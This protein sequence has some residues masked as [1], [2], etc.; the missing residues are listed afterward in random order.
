[1]SLFDHPSIFWRLHAAG[2]LAFTAIYTLATME[3]LPWQHAI[4][5]KSVY[6]AMGCL[7]S[8]A[9]RPVCARA[10]RQSVAV[11]MVWIGLACYAGGLA[12]SMLYNGIVQL[13]GITPGTLAWVRLGGSLGMS[14]TLLAWCALYF[15]ASAA[16]DLERREADL[17]R[18]RERALIAQSQAR[19]AQLRALRY[20]LDPHFL[21]N[22][23]NGVTTLIAEHRLDA[24][25]AMIARLADFLRATLADRDMPV[26]TLARD[27]ELADRYLEIE[28]ERY[29][30]RLDV[31]IEPAPD[32]LD[33][34]VPALLLQPL[35][36]NAVRHG[37]ARRP[38]GGRLSL[39]THR[40]NGRVTIVVE[41]H[42][43]AGGEAGSADA[44]AL[45]IGLANARA[46]LATLFD[47]D[48]SLE[49]EVGEMASTVRID[50]PY[51]PLGQAPS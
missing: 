18:E 37:I 10:R 36:E 17:A 4:A 6:G 44:P 13:T 50:V 51:R 1:V 38:A 29:C 8:L 11:A 32:A 41:D 30:D 5:D 24:A 47:D 2:W 28:R 39:V 12:W 45:G 15:G 19:D 27:L 42:A 22:T 34:R 20:Q 35:V 31:R 7:V 25:R 3:A 40:H 26:V 49:L 48:F 43:R 21:F 16:R 46:R 9:L 14:G 23:L 33:A